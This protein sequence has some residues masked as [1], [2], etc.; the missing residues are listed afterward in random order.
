[1]KPQPFPN[2][3]TVDILLAAKNEWMARALEAERRLAKWQ[4]WA[5]FIYLGG[6]PLVL[7]DD[8]ELQRLVCQTHDG[9]LQKLKHELEV[10]R[11]VHTL[12]MLPLRRERAGL[13]RVMCARCEKVTDLHI[14]T[15]NAFWCPTCEKWRRIDGQ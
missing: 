4:A 1:M 7:D 10:Q 12:A 11:A 9:E 2:Q 14:R 13:R 5:Q 3:Q 8:K 15:E 6:G